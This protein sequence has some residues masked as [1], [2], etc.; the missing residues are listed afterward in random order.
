MTRFI[1]NALASAARTQAG[2]HPNDEQSSPA[3]A[4]S[5]PAARAA[6]GSRART[7]SRARG[8]H[9]IVADL[10]RLPHRVRRREV[11]RRAVA[12]RPRRHRRSSRCLARCRH[13]GQ[14]RG[15]PAVSPIAEFVP[16]TSARCSDSWSSRRSCS[17][18]RRCRRCTE[19]GWGRVVNISSAHGCGR[20]RSSR[21]TSPRSTARRASRRSPRSRGD[22]TE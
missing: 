14:Q 22:R 10:T 3:S 12:H 15:H 19:R 11:G 17:S 9:V 2:E 6:S 16:R 20:A 13:P 5:S 1:D 7:S 21:P 8:A 18:A 4:R